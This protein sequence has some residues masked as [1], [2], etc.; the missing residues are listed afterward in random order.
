MS[1][2][3]EELYTLGLSLQKIVNYINVGSAPSLH[4]YIKTRGIEKRL[5]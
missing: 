1:T 3:K 4:K 2:V 5:F